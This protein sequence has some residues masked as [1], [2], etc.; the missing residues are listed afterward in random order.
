MKTTDK[1]KIKNSFVFWVS[2]PLKCLSFHSVP[3]FE[4]MNFSDYTTMWQMV[5]EFV[6]Q[7]YVVQ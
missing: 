7:G 5:H 4:T 3:R 1:N 2:H 6:Q